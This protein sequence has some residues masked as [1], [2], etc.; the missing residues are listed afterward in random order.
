ML[1]QSQA[2]QV[3]TPLEQ[4]LNFDE[5]WWQSPFERQLPYE[6][7]RSGMQYRMPLLDP[8]RDPYRR[9]LDEYDREYPRRPLERDP[10]RPHRRFRR[11]EPI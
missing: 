7:W 5:R 1:R 11:P 8:R 10:E 6:A 4:A 9:R 3:P 2:Q